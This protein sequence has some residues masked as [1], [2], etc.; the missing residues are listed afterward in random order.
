ML[1]LLSPAKTLDFSP[2]ESELPTTEPAL[3][4]DA[5]RLAKQV[6]QL[7]PAEL[8]E[9]MGI[10]DRLAIA[11]HGYFASWKA[12][13]A[14]A[15]RVS[16]PAALAF[17][18]DV[19]QGLAADDFHADDWEF[20]QR[21]VRILSGLYGVL[22]PLDRIQP[23]RLEMGA[24]LATERGDNLYAYWGERIRKLLAKELRAAESP[25][26]VNL[27]SQE[28]ARAARLGELAGQAITPSFRD[29]H[30]GKYKVLS[31]F[32]KRARGAMARWLVQRRIVDADDVLKF[33]ADGYRLNRELSTADAP[34]FTRDKP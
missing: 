11:T 23:Y 2:L 34:V 9:L 31:F 8:R 21:H 22:W 20:A 13:S 28:Y 15:A 30:D 29:R 7:A 6:K 14:A 19:Y 17:R 18:G 25:T 4:T 5:N 33:R 24:P 27:A 12:T 1:I 16:K 26:I 32:A 3:L 10:S